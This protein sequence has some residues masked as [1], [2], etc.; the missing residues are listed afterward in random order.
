M[1]EESM[2]KKIKN[3]LS[4]S[5]YVLGRKALRLGQQLRGIFGSDVVI[6]GSYNTRNIGDLA[7][8]LSIKNQLKK[9]LLLWDILKE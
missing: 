1:R 6:Q 4:M 5:K 9:I 3:H 8:G 2:D 7:I